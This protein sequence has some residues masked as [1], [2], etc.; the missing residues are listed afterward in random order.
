MSPPL[1]TQTQSEAEAQE[2][3]V[4]GPPDGS[5]DIGA[6]HD[7]ADGSK[8]CAGVATMAVTTKGSASTQ[9]RRRNRISFAIKSSLILFGR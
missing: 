9:L 6:D 4:G 3:A 1:S 5:I 7:I 2:T 8:A